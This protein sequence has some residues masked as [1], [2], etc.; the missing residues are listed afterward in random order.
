[1][2][3]IEVKFL[4]IDPAEIEK[5]LL[6]LGALKKYDRIFKDRVFDFTGWPLDANYSWLRLRDKGDKLTL[7]YKR[8]F[9]ID[10]DANDGG[11]EE[12]EIKV[13]DFEKTTLLLEK[14]G[15]VQ[16]FNEEKRRVHF[17]LDGVDVDIDTW[18]L[19]EPYI[20]I[21]GNSWDKVQEMAEKLGLD[22][23][24]RKMLAAMQIYEL[25]GINEKEYSV[26]T[27]DKQ[28]RRNE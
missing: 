24:D 13:D 10:K 12:V 11:M 21:E 1:M 19:L 4:G 5:K 14:I 7:S 17:E 6:S 26:L 15:M 2:E 16:K 22:W 20:E 9:G 23:N 28:I 27:F 8:R 25:K 3:E 18:P